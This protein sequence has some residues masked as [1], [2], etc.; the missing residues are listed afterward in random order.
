MQKDGS[1][2]DVLCLIGILEYTKRMGGFDRFEQKRGTYSRRRKIVDAKILL[3]GWLYHY[4]Y[5]YDTE[6]DRVHKISLHENDR[7]HKTSLHFRTV[8]A[9][10]LISNFSSKKRTVAQS[11]NFVNKKPKEPTS[12]RVN[13][14]I[15]EK[16]K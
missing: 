10:N 3:F 8:L 1:K 7:V 14:R 16:N 11:P 5:L 12:R 4:K 13:S 6:N 2:S 15:L 9:R